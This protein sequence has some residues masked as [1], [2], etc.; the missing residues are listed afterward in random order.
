MFLRRF[1]WYRK[2]DNFFQRGKKGYCNEDLWDIYHWFTSLFPIMLED[3]MKKANGYPCPF[4]PSDT[5][6]IDAWYKE[7]ERKWKYEVNKLIWFLKEAN[8][9]TCSQKNEIDFDVNFDFVKTDFNDFWSELKL[10]YPTE[11]DEQKSKKHFERS[12]EI[13][14]YKKECFNKALRQ[15]EKISRNLWD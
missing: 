4:P 10:T 6:D 12:K 8:D 15:F 9:F 13:A 7:Q 2:L 5:K 1:G 11:E 14:D 3:F